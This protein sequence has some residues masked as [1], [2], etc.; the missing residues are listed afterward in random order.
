[1]QATALSSNW[2]LPALPIICNTSESLK[3]IKNMKLNYL[4]KIKQARDRRHAEHFGGRTSDGRRAERWSVNRNSSFRGNSSAN[5]SS[6]RNSSANQLH[7]LQGSRHDQLRQEDSGAN[8]QLVHECD[9][10]LV[11]CDK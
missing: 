8:F 4:D 3:K 5:G 2:G 9:V 6:P 7:S 10:W 11:K 1:M